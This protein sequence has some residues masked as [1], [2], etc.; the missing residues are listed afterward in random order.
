MAVI[1][2]SSAQ[3]TPPTAS[4]A[5]LINLVR[6]CITISAPNSIGEIIIGVNVLSITSL[7]D[8]FFVIDASDGIS[9]ISSNGLLIVSQ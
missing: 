5:P 6:E 8:V 3:T 2:S 7:I 4:E 1:N 9:A